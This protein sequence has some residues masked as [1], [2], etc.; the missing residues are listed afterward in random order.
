MKARWSRSACE[1][2]ATTHPWPLR[3]RAAA[4]S[5]SIPPDT[6]IFPLAAHFG[7]FDFAEARPYAF[8]NIYTI[9]TAFAV[10]FLAGIGARV[11]LRAERERPRSRPEEPGPSTAWPERRQDGP[12]PLARAWRRRPW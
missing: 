9:I 12:P 6:L 10:R 11:M 2:A 5:L 4:P 3:R 7:S 8:Q 1:K